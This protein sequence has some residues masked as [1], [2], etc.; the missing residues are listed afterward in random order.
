MFIVSAHA[1]RMVID[2]LCSSADG[3]PPQVPAQ[4]LR[5][6]GHKVGAA[7]CCRVP[8]GCWT[9]PR[10][11]LVDQLLDVHTGRLG[12]HIAVAGATEPDVTECVTKPVSGR[13]FHLSYRRCPGPATGAQASSSVVAIA[14]RIAG[15]LTTVMENQAPALRAAVTTAPA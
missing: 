3:R 7:T 8:T 2:Q 13:H 12:K 1:I 14:A 15:L 5:R 4:E 11:D 6:L 9:R 10:T